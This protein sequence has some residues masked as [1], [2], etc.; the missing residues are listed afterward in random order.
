MTEGQTDPNSLDLYGHN[1]GSHKTVNEVTPIKNISR[2]PPNFLSKIN[3][4][5]E[6]PTC[7]TLLNHEYELNNAFELRGNN[8]EFARANLVFQKRLK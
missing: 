6:V 1:W 8:R 4:R 5:Q 7:H 2:N 3:V